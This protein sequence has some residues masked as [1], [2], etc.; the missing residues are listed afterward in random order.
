MLP[1]DRASVEGT[2]LDTKVI[3]GTPPEDPLLAI[4]RVYFKIVRVLES[5]DA[6]R[7]F[8]ISK[9]EMANA[10][11]A[12]RRLDINRDGTLS[13]EECGFSAGASSRLPADLVER[14]RSA[15][16][17]INP[18]L[19]ALDSDGDGMISEAEITGSVAALKKLDRNGDDALAPHE[20]LPARDVASAAF[21]IVQLDAD[22]DGRIS[23]AERDAE[24]AKTVR[25]LLI[26]ADRNQDG[27]ATE[28][29]LAGEI[30][31]RRERKLQFDRARGAAGL[32]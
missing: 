32:R 16:M 9:P 30:R 23:Q 11:A 22:G 14:A 24:A 27:L 5:F 17:R 28:E 25:E 26:G 7:D 19:A 2:G 15:F 10:P 8:I 29:E 6:D 4:A 12:L 31:L 21:V 1:V 13:A 20:I 18:V 3:A